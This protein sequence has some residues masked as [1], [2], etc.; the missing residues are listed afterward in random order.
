MN[1]LEQQRLLATLYTNRVIR[2]EYFLENQDNFTKTEITIF[3]ESLVRK[4]LHVVKSLMPLSFSLRAE[5][6]DRL[7]YEYAASNTIRGFHVKHQQDALAFYD[8]FSQHEFM[9]TDPYLKEVM[10]YERFT[11]RTSMAND[12]C[13][14]FYGHFRFPVA[15]PDTIGD[16]K[17]LKGKTVLLFYRSFSNAKWKKF[18]WGISKTIPK[19]HGELAY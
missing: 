19:S 10:R 1:L 4:R 15:K 8:F 7:F 6:L 9:K 14:L 2:E 16:Q 17:L 13:L 18:I 3:A 5:V 12:R 11:L